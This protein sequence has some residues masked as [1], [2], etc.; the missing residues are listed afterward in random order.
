MV[1][2]VAGTWTSSFVG[3][4]IRHRGD[5][6]SLILVDA[7]Y[8]TPSIKKKLPGWIGEKLINPGNFG[9]VVREL[10]NF[11]GARRQ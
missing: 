2:V 9:Q 11:Y 10:G 1:V 3:R 4:A 7:R 5:W 8:S 6:A